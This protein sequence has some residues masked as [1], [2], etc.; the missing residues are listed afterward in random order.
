M[1]F[2]NSTDLPGKSLVASTTDRE[3]LAM[4]ACKV[5][6]LLNGEG[7]LDPLQPHEMWPIYAEP[8]IFNGVNLLPELEYRKKGVDILVFGEAVAHQN[9]LG[10]APH[11]L[12]AADLQAV[13]VPGHPHA[14]FIAQR[15]A[16]DA[17]YVLQLLP[18]YLD[19]NVLPDEQGRPRARLLFQIQGV[20]HLD[21][22][23]RHAALGLQIPEQL[24]H[25]ATAFIL[26][27]V[28]DPHGCA[29]LPG[30]AGD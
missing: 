3:Q 5:T 6:Y 16:G 10:V 15:R 27:A 14:V 25:C 1:Q 8:S 7:G 4:V 26:V 24:D 20:F 11:G 22:Q 21:Q 19:P 18:L 28:D 29:L 12:H 9:A 30:F 17:E 23:P 13:V 2:I